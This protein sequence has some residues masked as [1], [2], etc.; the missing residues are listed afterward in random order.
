MIWGVRRRINPLLSSVRLFFPKKK[1]RR[2]ILL[3]RG[4]PW[5]ESPLVFLIKP[6]MAIVWPSLLERTVLAVVL[7]K[8]GTEKGEEELA[9][10]AVV[11]VSF[12]PISLESKLLSSIESSNVTN[13]P[14]L[15]RGVRLRIVP[16]SLYSIVPSTNPVGVVAVA[17]PVEA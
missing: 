11:L 15:I 7:L 16:I 8:A 5:L 4:T 3:K 6:P 17:V 13:P 14:Q 10:A 1:P 2:G 12:L 9:T